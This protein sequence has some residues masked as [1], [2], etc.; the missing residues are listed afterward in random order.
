LYQWALGHQQVN[1][2]DMVELARQRDGRLVSFDVRLQVHDPEGNV[3]T[4]I[5]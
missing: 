4:V 2:A 5:R 3:V 1:D